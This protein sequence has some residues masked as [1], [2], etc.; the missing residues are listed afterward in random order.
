MI[1]R[2]WCKKIIASVPYGY[3]NGLSHVGCHAGTHA[4]V[5]QHYAELNNR[6]VDHMEWF[7]SRVY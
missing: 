3:A 5:D 2:F 4:K 6:F 7:A 1:L